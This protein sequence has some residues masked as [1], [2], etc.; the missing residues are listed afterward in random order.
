LG[1]KSQKKAFEQRQ[2]LPNNRSLTLTQWALGEEGDL[3]HFVE[4]ILATY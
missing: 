4:R 3:Y 2:N 1:I